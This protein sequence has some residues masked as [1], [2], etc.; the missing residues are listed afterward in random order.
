MEE[1]KVR[2]KEA[3]LSFDNETLEYIVTNKDLL[4]YTPKGMIPTLYDYWVND[5]GV[6][7]EKGK[8]QLYPH[9]PYET[10]INTR[11]AISFYNDNNPD[12]L[13]IM[14]FYH[15]IGH[16]DFFQNNHMFMH[17]WKDDFAGQALADK[18]FIS[19]H[20]SNHGRWVDYVIEFARSIDNIVG[21]FPHLYEIENHDILKEVKREEY[22]FGD[23][24]QSHVKLSEMKLFEEIERYNKMIDTNGDLGDN[25]YFSEV[26]KK[27]PEFQ[28]YFE[29]FIKKRKTKPKDIL[30]FIIDNSPFLKKDG[31]NWMKGI[32][33]IVRNTSLYFAPQIR[34][35]IINEGWASYWHDK[36]FQKDDRIN[37]HEVDYARVNAAVT[38]ISRIGLNPYAIGLRLINHVEDLANE[39]KLTYQF[40]K[41]RDRQKRAQYDKNTN[42]GKEA[43]FMLRKYFSDHMLINTFVDQDFVDEHNLFVTG[44][45][46]N[47]DSGMI[48]YYVK[49]RRAQDYKKML[50]DQLYHPPYIS[51]NEE[52]TNDNNIYLVHHFEG[53]Q[54]VQEM[55]PDTL[56]GLE[57]LWGGQAQLETTQIVVIQDR[58]PQNVRYEHRRVLYTMKDKKINSQNL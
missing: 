52:K 28:S 3:G 51:I 11:P 14:I 10:V 35:K 26:K 54:L 5:V 41:I 39:G 12:W 1:C 7:K 33:N 24:L 53:K 36:L 19:S 45:R 13:N 30:E 4:E 25:L 44:Q 37:G 16:I 34:T 15:V 42:N 40:Q 46:F 50:L 57:Y 27:Y 21:Y 22:F 56:L 18:R 23:F 43:I 58:N 38:S 8:Y 6:L 49:S 48:E 2:A 47:K 32:L 55:I 20:R 17:T 9:N 31:N 29:Q